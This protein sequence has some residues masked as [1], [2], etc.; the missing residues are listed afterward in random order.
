[1]FS[2]RIGLDAERN[3]V[4]IDVGVRL[5][6]KIGSYQ[7]GLLDMQTRQVDDR[8]PGNNY[9]VARVSRELPNRSSIGVIAIN[10][11]A[12]SSI[13]NFPGQEDH[14]RSFGADANFGI[15]SFANVFNYYAKTKT[16]GLNGS[17]HA[18]ATSLAYDD[19]I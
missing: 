4:P 19:A 1:F 5:S 9:A 3:A 12:T 13:A 6:G 16:P 8:A 11:E 7:V 2:R 18:G 14:N 10:R 17:D 15:G